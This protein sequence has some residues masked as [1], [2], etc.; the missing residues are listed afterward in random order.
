[1]RPRLLTFDIF[2][3]VVD[4]QQGISQALPSP[5]LSTAQFEAVIDRQG[6]LEGGPFR[7]YASIVAQSLVEVLALPPERAAAL[8]ARA[9]QW[10]LFDDATE[11]LR[12]LLLV[13]PCVAM[14]NS[15]RT[16]GLDVQEQLGFALSSWLCAEEVHRYKPDPAFWHAVAVRRG[17]T[18]SRDWWH[19]SAYADYDLGPARALGLTTVFVERPHARPSAKASPGKKEPAA[20]HVV[21]DLRALAQ[22]CEGLG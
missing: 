9:G 5:G 10:P 15:D 22:L 4:W 8:A 2:G 11:G 19:V 7:N 3:T 16:H 20:D 13:A 12:R 14:T 6:A 18:P 1:M 21:P 17:L